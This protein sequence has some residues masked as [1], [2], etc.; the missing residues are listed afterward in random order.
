MEEQELLKI[1]E[2]ER[3]QLSNY[4]KKDYRYD[5]LKNLL[6]KIEKDKGPLF[7]KKMFLGQI[8][9]ESNKQQAIYE[10]PTKE[11]IDAIKFICDYLEI[12]DIEEI[13]AGMGL[14]SCMLKFGLGESYNVSASDGKRWIET[15]SSNKYYPVEGKLFL[16]YCLDST[17][18]FQNKLLIISW[19]P[20]GD[21]T[22]IFKIIK[23][24]NPEN[25]IIIGNM[26][27]QELYSVINSKLNSYNY[28]KIGIP[29]KQLC[30]KDN[31]LNNYS[32]SS[33]MF[34]TNNNEFNFEKFMLSFKLK[35]DNCLNKKYICKDN[36]ILLDIIVENFHSYD[37]LVNAINSDDNSKDIIKEIYYC[38]KKKITVPQYFKDLA[39]FTFW[40]DRIKDKKMPINIKD[41]SKFIEYK[42]LIEKLTEDNGINNLKNKGV[43]PSWIVDRTQADQYLWLDYSTSNKKWK[44]GYQ[45]FRLEFTLIYSQYR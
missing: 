34:V 9:I 43:L 21:L 10:L 12:K 20:C 3:Y 45:N 14:L 35:C 28:K 32:K 30:F 5:H 36:D 29:V 31:S 23:D 19:I 26:F 25:I 2:E 33:F 37:F 40:F 16:N 18:S 27:D 44:S 1:F 11:L 8:G 7:I 42:K 6:L 17:F 13:A 41:Y 39:E 15:S 4:L 24:K 22:D 38:I